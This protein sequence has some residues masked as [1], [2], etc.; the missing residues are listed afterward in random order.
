MEKY[1]L[2]SMYDCHI[3]LLVDSP[4]DIEFKEDMVVTHGMIIKDLNSRN[5][6]LIKIKVNSSAEHKEF[7]ATYRKFNYYYNP[8]TKQIVRA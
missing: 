3:R 8:E 4:D 5:S 6:I 7:M 1:M 2:I